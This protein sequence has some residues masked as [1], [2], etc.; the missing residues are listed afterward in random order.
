MPT[1]KLPSKGTIVFFHGNAE[2]LSSHFLN[3]AWITH[4]G[5]NLFIFDYRGYGASEGSVNQKGI[6]EDS[7]AALE[8]GHD[9]HLKTSPQGKFIV[10]G[11]SLGGIVSLRALADWQYTNKVNLIVQDSTFTSYQD[12][13]FDKLKGFWLT[14][15]ISP[16]AYVL[17]SDEF[18]SDKIISK[19]KNPL[20]VIS[21]EKDFVVPFKFSQEL[22]KNSKSER[23]WFWEIKDGRHS[24]VFAFN[25]F[26]YRKQFLLFLETI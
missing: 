13:A 17:V 5:Y 23:K 18:A 12:I 4:E 21:G 16:L 8:K 26:K 6:Y 7:F 11:Q 15:L 10:Y 25:E 22:Y 19:I 2:N 24:D 14:F 20:L 3:L 1:Q 9:L